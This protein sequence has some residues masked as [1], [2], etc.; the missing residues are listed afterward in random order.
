M[1]VADK[2]TTLHLQLE[3]KETK[4]AEADKKIADLQRQLD[5]QSHGDG[6]DDQHG[7]N[8]STLIG[9]GKPDKKNISQHLLKR[10]NT[11]NSKKKNTNDEEESDFEDSEE[12]SNESSSNKDKKKKKK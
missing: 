9:S 4:L 2:A 12:E 1:S 7:A 8:S 6:H 10:L 5:A 3:D 11:A